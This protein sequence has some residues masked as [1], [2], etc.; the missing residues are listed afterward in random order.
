MISLVFNSGSIRNMETFCT[1]IN[2][3]NPEYHRICQTCS[4]IFFAWTR[5][6][7]NITEEW[8]VRVSNDYRI[9]VLQH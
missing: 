8:G 4:W 5:G 6:A 3:N 7:D 2:A 9:P 1:G